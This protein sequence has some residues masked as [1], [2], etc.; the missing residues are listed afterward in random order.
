V[1]GRRVRDGDRVV[2]LCSEHRGTVVSVDDR[3]IP[4]VV[5]VKRDDLP[6]NMA[7]IPYDEDEVAVCTVRDGQ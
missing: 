2:V 3:G 5:L 7:P 6:A 4:P 1:T